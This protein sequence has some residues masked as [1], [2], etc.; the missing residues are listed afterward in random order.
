M[1]LAEGF[2]QRFGGTPDL[3]VRAPGR[4][5]LIGEHTDYN[6][7]FAMPVAIGSETRV[8]LRRRRDEQ[9][10]VAAL[11]FGEEDAFAPSP[12]LQKA[13]L[14][15][16]RD[17]IRGTVAILAREG[18]DIGG[19]DIAVLGDVPMGTGLSSSASLEVAVATAILALAGRQEDP[20]RVAL[21]AQAAENDF[22][23]MRCGNLDQL[24]SA[25]TVEGAALLIDCRSLDL[26]PVMMPPDAAVMI[27]QSGVVRGL[28]EGHYNE[29][30][31]QCEQAAAVL[32]VP[33]LRDA[34]LAMLEGVA[35]DVDALIVRRA[36][37]VITENDRTL[38]AAEALELGDLHAVGVLMRESHASQRD[39][40]EI[41]V[42]PTDRLAELMSE[43]IGQDGGARQTGG[44]FGGA[45]VGLMRDDRVEAVRERVLSE[46]RTPSGELPDVRI[47]RA[48]SGASAEIVQL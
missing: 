48:C 1:R 17:Y 5:N 43:A 7:G 21:W 3:V 18:V 14:G 47:E 46:Y 15:G 33:A 32:G 2:A 6:D 9:I 35:A 23:G 29:R 26:R 39:D 16:W 4:V 36:R 31:R 20:K 27:V 22:V 13:A 24:A 40:F 42:P 11:N 28:V 10:C 25:A 41:T 45:V 34:N 37:H 19:L 8:A 12:D 44:G 30:R 38:A